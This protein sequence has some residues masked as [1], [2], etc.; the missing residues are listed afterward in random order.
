MTTHVR[1]ISASCWCS[2]TEVQIPVQW[3]SE[4]RTGSCGKGCGPGCPVHSDGT[5][6]FDDL[7]EVATIGKKKRMAKFDANTYDPRDDSSAGYANGGVRIAHIRAVILETVAPEGTQ[8]LCPCGCAEPPKGK[9]ATFGMGHDARLKGKLARAFAGN[10]EIVLTDASKNV[11]EVLEPLQFAKRFNSD[12]HDWP[13]EIQA[14]ADRA[15][16]KSGVRSKD[17]ADRAVLQKAL[18]PQVGLTKLLKIGRW[19]RTGTVLAVYDEGGTVVYEYSD[20]KGVT[21]R[22][23][24]GADGKLHEVA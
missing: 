7:T 19:E 22:V 12:K 24:Q 13:V 15:A 1:T 6:A 8:A 20:A 10:C 5:D 9:K 2:K 16:S 3:V 18:D 14:S 23:S 17:D 11:H 21:H 4:A